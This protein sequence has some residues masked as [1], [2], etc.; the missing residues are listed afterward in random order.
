MSSSGPIYHLCRLC[1]DYMQ[2]PCVLSSLLRWLFLV[3]HPINDHGFVIYQHLVGSSQ[4]VRNA[5]IVYTCIPHL[6]PRACCAT[7]TPLLR[8]ARWRCPMALNVPSARRRLR[9][10]LINSSV[11][12]LALPRCPALLLS[13]CHILKVA[14]GKC[15]NHDHPK[16]IGIYVQSRV[17]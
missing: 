15:K 1:T 7:H 8:T 14:L 16:G 9:M 6:V 12:R 4:T 2:T 10:P 11:E 17:L 5:Y 3:V 13:R